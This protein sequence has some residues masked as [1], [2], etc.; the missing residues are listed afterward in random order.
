MPNVFRTIKRSRLYP[1]NLVPARD[2]ISTGTAW[3]R[4][5]FHLTFISAYCFI[6]NDVTQVCE[7]DYQDTVCLTYFNATGCPLSLVPYFLPC[8]LPPLIS[9]Y[10]KISASNCTGTVNELVASETVPCSPP[11]PTPTPTIP[12]PSPSSSVPTPNPSS[13]TGASVGGNTDA[14]GIPV[15]AWIVIAIAIILLIV[16]VVLIVFLI[17]KR[18]INARADRLSIAQMSSRKFEKFENED[19]KAQELEDK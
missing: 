8:P 19:E 12:S 5:W 13:A 2:R 18:R 3:V 15:W 9:R 1:Q 16:V 10:R 4:E 11:V 7:P 6:E 17:R 14:A